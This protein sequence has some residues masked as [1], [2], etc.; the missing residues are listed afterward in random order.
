[1]EEGISHL[2]LPR[3]VFVFVLFFLFVEFCRMV[4]RNLSKPTVRQGFTLI[5][6]LVVIAIIGVL[7]AILLPAVQKAREAAWRTQCTNNLKQMGVAVHNFEGVYS[8][9]IPS[10]MVDPLAVNG[11]PA[12]GNSAA[13]SSIAW[14]GLMLPHVEAGSLYDKLTVTANS[15]NGQ[16][17]TGATLNVT[18]ASLKTYLC[19]SRRSG[20]Q[21][22][23]NGG[24]ACID[25]AGVC[26]LMNVAGPLNLCTYSAAA[27]TNPLTT[28]GGAMLSAERYGVNGSG[29]RPRVSFASITDG[30][31]NTFA[32]GEK[33]LQKSDLKNNGAGDGNGYYYATTNTNWTFTMRG[34]HGTGETI[35]NTTGTNSLAKKGPNDVTITNVFGS[36]HSGVTQFLMCDGA[37][38]QIRTNADKNILYYLGNRQDGTPVNVDNH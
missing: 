32:I 4:Q 8:G 26:T 27:A 35:P 36:W 23:T 15:Y 16:T 29:F 30:L 19:P 3:P 22:P 21:Q 38:K 6:L 20:I 11:T 2:G 34:I 17:N 10:N 33:H 25:Y 28:F 12:G 13:S 24:G 5:E 1:V 14:T 31:S 18:G 37:V 7:V 9:M